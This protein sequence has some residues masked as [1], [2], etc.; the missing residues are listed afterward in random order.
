MRQLT[1]LVVTLLATAILAGVAC[2]DGVTDAISAAKQAYGGGDYKETSTQLQT[3]LALV[4]QQLIDLL[5]DA[6]PDPPSGWTAD[7]AEGIDAAAMGAG[8]F[9]TL[10]VERTYRTPDGSRISLTISASSPMLISL[11]MF[12]SNP[13]MAAMAGQTGMKKVTVCG[14]D[15]LEHFDD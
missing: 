10:V 13:M 11:R 14:Y 8:F 12:I 9:A 3:A 6:L 1:A 7:E 2:A 5:V 4:N 15:A